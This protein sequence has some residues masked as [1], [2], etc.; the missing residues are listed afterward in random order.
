[1]MFC[2]PSGLFS[3]VTLPVAETDGRKV[4][5]LGPGLQRSRDEIRETKS[6]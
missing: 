2:H 3:S 4:Q 5:F 6:G 1:M